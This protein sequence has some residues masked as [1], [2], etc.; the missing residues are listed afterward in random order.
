MSDSALPS[1]VVKVG[2]SLLDWP[3]LPGRL[4]DFLAS[5]VGRLSRVVLIA[6][7]GPT[8]D[9]IRRLDQVH[10]FG[11]AESHWLA[12][13]ALDLTARILGRLLPDARVIDDDADV[14][15]CW[16][17]GVQPIL[18][19]GRIFRKLDS[20][21]D[22]GLPATWDVTSDS[23]AAWIAERLG[24]DRLI[25]IKSR[26]MPAGSS[27]SDAVAAGFVDPLFPAAARSLRRVDYRNLRDGD[28]G[29]I[30][31]LHEN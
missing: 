4:A 19:P 3:E 12:I 22:S 16:D 2:G 24:A 25:L 7:G 10:Q 21:S 6:G 5:D 9:V 18:S 13:D 27:R 28:G 17:A 1:V 11:E 29:L 23:I 8:V 30:E 14:Q 15:T 31:L 26:G 20:C